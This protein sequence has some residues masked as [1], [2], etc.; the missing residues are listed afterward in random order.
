M[1]LSRKRQREFT[2]LKRQAE[3]L[4]H[5][6]R[7]VLEHATRV[8][9]DASRQAANYAREDVAPRVKDTYEDRIRP[10]VN[11]G[12]SATR[13][14][15]TSTR[16]KF[17][18]DVFPAVTSALGSALAVIEAAKSPHVREALGRATKSA[19]KTANA[20]G[21]KTGLVQQKSGPG[22]YILIGIGV[23]AFAG[24]AYAAWQT[25][26]ADDDLWIDDEE[27]L[28]VDQADVETPTA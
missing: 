26:R 20:V 8:V 21:V 19:A 4:V 27:L 18:D 28:P 11:T 13:H 3:E 23:V 6:Q 5:D 17:V 2:K 22:K 15:A 25:L 24:I 10:V 12:V 9:R 16:D 7:D 14:A 1:G